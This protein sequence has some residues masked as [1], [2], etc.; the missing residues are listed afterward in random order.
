[1]IRSRLSPRLRIVLAFTLS[2]KARRLLSRTYGLP[3]HLRLLPTPP[4]GDA[5]TFDYWS[6]TNP[7]TDLHRADKASSRTHSW[8]GVSR[9]PT[10]RRLYNLRGGP[11]DRGQV[12]GTRPAMTERADPSPT[13][14]YPDP[15]GY[16]LMATPGHNDMAPPVRQR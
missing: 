13:T 11:T 2:L 3:I 16:I 4:C 8:P 12:A 14:A 1:M 15:H 9:P 10:H 6:A 5:V 7:G